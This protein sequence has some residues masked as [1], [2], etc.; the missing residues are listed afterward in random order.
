MSEK[1]QP[2]AAKAAPKVEKTYYIVNP[3]GTIHSVDRAH[4]AWRLRTVGW[5]MATPEEVQLLRDAGG[6]QRADSPIATP[7]SPDPDLGPEIPE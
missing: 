6:E 3:K 2:K 4:A 7:W 5:R 1:P